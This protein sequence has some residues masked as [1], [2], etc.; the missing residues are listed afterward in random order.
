M[1][2]LI[3]QPEVGQGKGPGADSGEEL[4]AD[5]SPY[6]GEDFQVIAFFPFVPSRQE[7]QV[8]ILRAH[9]W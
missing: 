5:G 4:A 9:I 6:Q 7:Q 3:Q 2:D 1:G 8:K